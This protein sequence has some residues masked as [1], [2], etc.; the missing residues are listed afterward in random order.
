MAAAGAAATDTFSFV[1][2]AVGDA[3]SEPVILDSNPLSRSQPPPAISL[4]TFPFPAKS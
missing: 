2:Y 3:F 4:R 1:A